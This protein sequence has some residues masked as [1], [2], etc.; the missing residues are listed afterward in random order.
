MTLDAFLERLHQKTGVAPVFSGGEYHAICPAHD[1]RTPS[2]SVSEADDRILIFCHANCGADDI[3]SALGIGLKD[4]FFD[5]NSP[6]AAAFKQQ[7]PEAEYSYEDKYGHEL[8]RVIRYP[9]KRFYHR[10]KRVPYHLPEVVNSNVFGR[11]IYI[12][13][14]EKDVESLRAAGKTATCNSGGAGKWLPEFSQ[15]FVGA[16]V[17]IVMDLDEIDPKTGVRSGEEHAKEVAA[18]LYQAA[19]KIHIVLPRQ[20]K[21]ATDHLE[22]GLRPED[23]VVYKEVK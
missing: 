19:E 11:S 16:R 10:F 2:L 7:E 21:D 15:Y 17:I 22:A 14:G 8:Y 18:M 6:E 1:D 3:V 12:V 5:S 9:G 20:G 13:E 23:F 4:L